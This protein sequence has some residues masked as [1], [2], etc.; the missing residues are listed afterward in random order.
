MAET[1]GC[2]LGNVKLVL[3]WNESIKARINECS[4]SKQKCMIAVWEDGER[5]T[6]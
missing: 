4:K 5:L 2:Q 3:F 1:T 6:H